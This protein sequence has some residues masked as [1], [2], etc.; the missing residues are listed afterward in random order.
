MRNRSRRALARVSENVVRSTLA[1]GFVRA[2]CTARCS[3][4]MVFPVP[5]E[6]DTLAGPVYSRSTIARWAG[7]R[8]MLHLSQG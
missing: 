7:C 2:R 1:L 3:A 6:P 4:T 8:K 5:A